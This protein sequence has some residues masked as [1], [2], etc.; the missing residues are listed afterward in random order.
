MDVEPVLA[1][2]FN[3]SSVEDQAECQS[4]YTN[5]ND[6]YV[7]DDIPGAMMMPMFECNMRE[8]ECCAE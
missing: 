3:K 6:A 5:F 2:C 1:P 8:G 7:R 4:L